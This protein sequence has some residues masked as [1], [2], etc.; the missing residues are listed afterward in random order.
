[1]DQPSDKKPVIKRNSV[2]FAPDEGVYAL[3]DATP[4]TA[5]FDPTIPAL[6]FSESHKGC[7]IVVLTT[8]KLQIGDHV[9]IQ[10][11]DLPVL[12][13][14]VRWREQVDPLIVKIG[15]MYLE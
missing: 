3:V 14:E 6:I 13:A 2:R 15:M 1:M 10:V 5:G 7:G 8:T 9:K 12:R 11:G 4:G